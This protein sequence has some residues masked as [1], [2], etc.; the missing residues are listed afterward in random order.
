MLKWSVGGG[1]LASLSLCAACCL[2]PMVLIGLGAGGAW[3]SS[4][5][6]L[7]PYKW[8]FIALTAALLGYGFYAAYWKPKRRCA[9]G[10]SCP[11]CGTSTSLRVVLWA[12]TILAIAGIAFERLERLASS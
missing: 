8:L 5:G 6:A 12:A 1:L 9:A 3:I 2:L 4:L 11:T 7:A 10:A